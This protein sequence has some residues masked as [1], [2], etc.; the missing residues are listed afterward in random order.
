[1][2]PPNVE[3]AVLV[4]V[5]YA[6]VGDVDE[7]IVVPSVPNH[8]CPNA[9]CPVPPR[10]TSRVPVVCVI[11]SESDP[12][13]VMLFNVVVAARSA[14]NAY[15]SEVVDHS[16]FAYTPFTES[17]FTE[18]SGSEDVA[19]VEVAWNRSA[20]VVPFTDNGEYGEVVPIPTYPVRPLITIRVLVDC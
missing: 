18:R 8:P 15:V 10:E 16:E 2:L 1:M 11:G 7:V 5:I 19:V 13:V 20:V 3:V 12:R 4:A 6:T 9:V 17:A 14:L